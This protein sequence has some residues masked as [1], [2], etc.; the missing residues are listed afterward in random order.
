MITINIAS[1][2]ERKEGLINTIESLYDQAHKIVVVLNGYD[3]VPKELKKARIK[4]FQQNNQFGAS[5]KF[6]KAPTKGYHFTCDDDIIYPKDYVR[7]MIEKIEKYYREACVSCYG[8]VLNKLPLKSYRHN[9]KNKKVYHFAREVKKDVKVHQLGTGCFAYHTDTIRFTMKD[10]APP[11]RKNLVDM[12]VMLKAQRRRV[13]TIVV[14]HEEGWLQY[15]EFLK[16]GYHVYKDNR[17]D[18][19]KKQH[20]LDSVNK[21]GKL[22]L[23]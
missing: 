13:K 5:A 1:I 7:K 21:L 19:V 20:Y 11:L 6:F 17:S 16:Y 23:Y 3:E 4:V 8:L 15:Q 9:I 12:C 2:P 18:P 14:Q 10:F 22:R